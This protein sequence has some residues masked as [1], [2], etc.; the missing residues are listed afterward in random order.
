MSKFKRWLLALAALMGV[1]A[2]A[3]EASTAAA[4]EKTPVVAV[5]EAVSAAAPAPAAI[6]IAPMSVSSNHWWGHEEWFSRSEVRWYAAV[7][8]RVS[9]PMYAA[10]NLAP[11]LG[12]TACR[13]AVGAYVGWVSG[14]FATAARYGQCVYW[15]MLWTGQ[16]ISVSRYACNWG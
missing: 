11:G 14:T 8:S 9:G 7:L 2:V 13:A 4:A 6:R 10:C 15:K 5:H 16:V 12:R 3:T 1:I